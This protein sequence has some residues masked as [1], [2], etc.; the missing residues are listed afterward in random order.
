MFLMAFFAVNVENFLSMGVMG[1]TPT[2]LPAMAVAVAVA[3]AVG[4]LAGSCVDLINGL[5][6]S[7]LCL[8]IYIY[9]MM[10]SPE[11]ESINK[12]RIFGRS[13]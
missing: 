1:A 6:D 2:K 12:I 11:M 4:I 9:E 8:P 10:T 13:K 3:V 5:L 7:Y